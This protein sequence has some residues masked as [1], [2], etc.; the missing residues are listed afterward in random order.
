VNLSCVDIQRHRAQ[1]VQV[2]QAADQ[3]R[4]FSKADLSDPS[5]WIRRSADFAKEKA[6]AERRQIRLALLANIQ[7][8]GSPSAEGFAEEVVLSGIKMSCTREDGVHVLTRWGNLEEIQSDPR[9]M[10][11]VLHPKYGLVINMPSHFRSMPGPAQWFY[12]AAQCAHTTHKFV[13]LEVKPWP[14][15]I[16]YEE[17]QCLSIRQLRDRKTLDSRQFEE[18]LSWMRKPPSNAGEEPIASLKAC[19]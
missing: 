3:T 6:A 1:L 19:W 18:L 14:K 9:N 10:I 16:S 4:Q 13:T 8:C 17:A 7:R 11:D 2:L 12:Y 15:Q 5:T